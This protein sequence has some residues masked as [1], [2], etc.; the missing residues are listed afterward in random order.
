MI[1]KLKLDRYNRSVNFIKTN[2]G[3]NVPILDLGIRNSLS[4]YIESKGF[5]VINTDGENLDDEFLKYA[6]R[7]VELITAFKIFEHMLAPYNFLKHVK[8]KKLVASV[9]L[10]LW[11][12]SAYW[13][14]ED[15]WDK[16]YHEFEKKQFDF[17]LKQ[18][19]WKW[20]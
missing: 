14:D 18:A 4:E 3:T 13:N 8:T 12:T 10:K 1:S 20:L 5:K 2:V 15:D 17:L 19:G 6:D 9:P 11:F 16:H 7:D